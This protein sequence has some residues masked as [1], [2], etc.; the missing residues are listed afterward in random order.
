[1]RCMFCYHL[2]AFC[3]GDPTKALAEMA[4]NDKLD[5]QIRIYSSVDLCFSTGSG[6]DMSLDLPCMWSVC[7]WRPIFTRSFLRMPKNLIR[8]SLKKKKRQKNSFHFHTHTSINTYMMFKCDDGIGH[9]VIVV[10]AEGNCRNL[11][12]HTCIW[13]RRMRDGA[14]AEGGRS[15][16]FAHLHR[17]AWIAKKFVRP[18]L[19]QWL[20]IIHWPASVGYRCRLLPAVQHSDS[21]PLSP[22]T[23][24]RT[25]CTICVRAVS[26]PSTVCVYAAPKPTPY[27]II[28]WFVFHIM[29]LKT[30]FSFSFSCYRFIVSVAASAAAAACGSD[31]RVHPRIIVEERVYS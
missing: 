17:P 20:A 27:K 30:F 5:V 3:A 12:V 19:R 22:S 1:M 23:I 11:L 29:I 8:Q 28:V 16:P 18:R 21:S 31:E 13:G 14:G 15:P 7:V 10:I 4:Q 25:F 9:R 26:M 6:L 2:F 24:R